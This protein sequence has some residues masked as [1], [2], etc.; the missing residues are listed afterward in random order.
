MSC[1]GNGVHSRARQ[2]IARGKGDVTARVEELRSVTEREVMACGDALSS[3]V[4]KARE[5]IADSD[6]HVATSMAR[7]EETMSRFVGGMQEDVRA[8]ESAVAHVLQLADGIEKAVNAIEKLT[9]SSHILAINCAI[10]AAHLGEKGRGFAVLATHMRELSGNIRSAADTV[11]SSI[12][13]VRAGLPP[14]MERATSM[15]ERTR[16]FTAEVSEQVRSASARSASGTAGG[17]LDEVLELSNVALSHLQFQDPV[18][19]SLRA[20]VRDIDHLEQ[21]VA[22]VLDGEA[23][24]EAKEPATKTPP[25]RARRLILF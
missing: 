12:K 24:T 7:S 5:L 25:A 11:T 4:D 3:L 18:A 9:Q 6:R 16:S 17:R 1:K 2:E 22:R 8:Q 21:R 19:Q 14:V 15:T 10:E 13:D 23:V 20:I